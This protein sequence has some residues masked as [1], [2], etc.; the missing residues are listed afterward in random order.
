MMPRVKGMSKPK[1]KSKKGKKE[2]GQERV[3]FWGLSF[4]PPYL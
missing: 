2:K 4:V 1:E 3:L